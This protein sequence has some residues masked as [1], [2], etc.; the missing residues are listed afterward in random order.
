MSVTVDSADS[1]TIDLITRVAYDNAAVDLSAA[2][3]VR[4]RDGLDRFNA[5]I[6]AGVPCYGVT[7]GL[8]KLSDA[9]LDDKAR[10]ELAKNILRARAA[11]IGEPLP[12][13]VVRAMMLLKLGNLLSGCDGTSPALAQFICDRLNDGFTPWVPAMGHG[14]AADAIAHTHCFQTLIGE[15]FVIADGA[16]PNSG[17]PGRVPAADALASRGLK[18]FEPA[19]KEGLALL[20][21]I[22]ATPAYALHGM[23]QARALYDLANAV[24]AL[25]MSAMAAPLDALD[26]SLASIAPEL[27]IVDSLNSINNWL[28]G[29][30]I[31][32][33]KLQAPVS[34]RVMPQV[35]G[36][37]ADCLSSLERS[38]EN[39]ARAFSDNPWMNEQGRLLSVGAFHN[40]HIV[41]HV[42]QT[43]TALVHVACLSERRLHRFMDPAMTGLNAQLAARPGLDAG[44][45]VLHKAM[46]EH[47]ARLRL[48]AQPV[49]VLT[50]ETSTGQEDYMS[51]S[52]PAIGRLL[53]ASALARTIVVAELMAGCVAL[54][55]RDQNAGRGVSALH[56]YTRTIVPPLHADRSP[57]PDL[58]RLL[59][60]S[61][62]PEFAGLIEA[63]T[64]TA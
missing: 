47:A 18:P 42:E 1:L 14:M 31:K 34:F 29:T 44:L 37:L 21:G 5:L 33:F 28:A 62:L 56:R 17:S 35:H 30:Q 55:Y 46:I 38:I 53:E 3:V 48:L 19:R 27:G 7:T 51:M 39:Q 58:E 10:T 9:T 24:A 25:S 23:K 15:G 49:S 52:M 20:N 32:P 63:Y 45:V 2:A 13:P 6:D 36:L 16:D 64:A 50:A 43:T 59:T 26:P 60:A 40:Q 8:G 12:V 41:T 61:S 54:D 4:M 22:A 11:A 57:G